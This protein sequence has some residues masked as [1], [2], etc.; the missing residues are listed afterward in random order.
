MTLSVT[1]WQFIKVVFSAVPEDFEIVATEYDICESLVVE[2]HVDGGCVRHLERKMMP[3]AP[4]VTVM[5][6]LSGVA[7]LVLH[8]AVWLLL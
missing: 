2:E 7:G 1:L 8:A 5:S 4:P 6:H 3:R